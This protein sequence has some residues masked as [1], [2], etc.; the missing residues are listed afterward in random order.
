MRVGIILWSIQLLTVV[1]CQKEAVT[2]ESDLILG[3]EYEF[4]AYDLE[5]PANYPPPHL[6]DDNP[7]S[8]AG[9]ELGR[10]LFY[11]PILSADSTQS[12]SS[13]HQQ[14]KAFTDGLRVSTGIL[15]LQ[16]IRNSMSLVNLAYNVNGFFWDGRSASL[17]EQA[18][19]PVEDHLEMNNTW[20]EVEDR[21][22]RHPEYPVRFKEAFGVDRYGQINRD[23]VVKAIAQFERTLITT[24][25]LYDRIL[26]NE[27][28]PPA[29][30]ERGRRLF[31]IEPTNQSENHPGCSHCH[32]APLMT[33]NRFFNN[34][35]DKVDD[36]A[37]FSDLGLGGVTGNAF[38]NGKFRAPSLRNIALTAPYMHDGRFQ[39]LDEVLDHYSS[40]GHGV[41]NED[42]NIQ[43]FTLTPQERE[44]LKAFLHALTDSTFI[45]NPAFANP[46]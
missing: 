22:R 37:G 28:F 4:V 40:G 33:T 38:D 27:V 31:I 21:L 43:P 9:V 23:L 6:P 34:G 3:G 32:G 5:L 1:A 46:F 10:R 44:D 2:E 18:L 29:D 45:T 24:N 36:L 26:R 8:V 11:D 20:E 25:S 39:T 7:L 35:L 17:E 42:P 14:Q 15:G 16:G 19:V 12:C 13:C 41:L 30:V